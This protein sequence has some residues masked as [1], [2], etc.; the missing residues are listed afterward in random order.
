[1]F[2][3]HH[4]CNIASMRYHD[5]NLETEGVVPEMPR[6]NASQDIHFKGQNDDRCKWR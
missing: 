2:G 3:L 5:N 6:L 4:A 1:M